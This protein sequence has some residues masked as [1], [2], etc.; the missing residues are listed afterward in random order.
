MPKKYRLTGDEIKNL[1]L[2]NGGRAGRRFHG[3]LFSLLVAPLPG[4]HPKFAV[5]ASKKVAVKAVD[6][7]KIK[8]RT[9]S[10]LAKARISISKPLALILYA[11]ADIKKAEYG[12]IVS[13][14]EALF[15]KI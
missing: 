1:F 15:S 2:P 5:V 12:E 4:T 9:R 11:K 13:D 14:I 10:V 6:R 3:K 8:R 7:N